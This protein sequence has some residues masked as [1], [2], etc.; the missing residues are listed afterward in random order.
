M[1]KNEIKIGGVY[2]AKVSGKLTDVRIDDEIPE[3]RGGG[4]NATN[5]ATGKTIRINHPQRLRAPS[6]AK[7]APPKNATSGNAKK[8]AAKDAKPA[9]KRDTA[10]RRG[11]KAKT[12]AKAPAKPKAKAKGGAK[13]GAK[14][15]KPKRVGCLGAAAQVLAANKRGPMSCKEMVEDMF[16]RKLWSTK[17]ATPEA[18]LYAAIIREIKNKADDSRFRKVERGRFELTKKGA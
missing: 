8:K 9:A 4:W 3:S 2:R 16:A 1:K 11:P 14:G 12:E 6:D 15:E 18:T 17:G 5:L 13:G 7:A 10:K